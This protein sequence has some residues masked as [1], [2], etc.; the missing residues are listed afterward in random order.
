MKNKNFVDYIIDMDKKF[1][2]IIPFIFN[3]NVEDDSYLSKIDI[4]LLNNLR[5]TY[6]YIYY[7][8]GVPVAGISRGP[9]SLLKNIKVHYIKHTWFKNRKEV[10]NYLVKRIRKEKLRKFKN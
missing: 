7:A 2:D 3:I 4:D 6:K 1:I 8:N 9:Y 5:N 10:E